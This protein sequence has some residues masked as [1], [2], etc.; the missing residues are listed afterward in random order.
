MK[1][2]TNPVLYGNEDFHT[3]Y[4]INVKASEIIEVFDLPPHTSFKGRT[5][6]AEDCAWV[7]LGM[8]VLAELG[9]P[10]N[11]NNLSVSDIVV[12][13]STYDMLSRY[14]YNWLVT[15]HT[16]HLRDSSEKT[17]H[18]RFGMLMLNYSPV[19]SDASFIEDGK[20]YIRKGR[21]P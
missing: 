16:K 19:A 9:D 6:D 1:K 3:T 11:D 13:M 14:S 10:D 18:S 15:K 20:V 17:R 7:K 2:L 21:K 12:S 8:F 4:P 5:K